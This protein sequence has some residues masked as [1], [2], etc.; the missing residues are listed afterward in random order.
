ME[1][2][3]TH[4]ALPVP[5]HWHSAPETWTITESGALTIVAGARTDL[6]IDPQTAAE[7]LNAPCL[8][9]HLA[10]D[11]MLSARVT[12]DFAA[13]FD[14][15]ALVLYTHDRVWA[16]LCLEYSPDGTAM[17]V[18]V[19]TRGVSDD[20]NSWRV[21]GKYA[22]LRVA[23]LGPAC[24]FHASADGIAWQFVRHFALPTEEKPAI[25]F[26]AQSPTGSR[27]SASFDDIRY[28]L[29]RLGDLRAGV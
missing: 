4:P 25:G 11:F 27:C 19:V 17:I 18:S 23:R 15:G 9:G 2:V 5:L 26:L 29:G 8:L 14:A 20:C 6:F 10:G 22:W 12:V 1:S 28:L 16:K 3:V 24:A 21:E 13:T 7:A